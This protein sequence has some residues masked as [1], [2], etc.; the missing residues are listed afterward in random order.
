MNLW[1]F[2][3]KDNIG[4]DYYY[5][6]GLFLSSFDFHTERFAGNTNSSRTVAEELYLTDVEKEVNFAVESNRLWVAGN[7]GQ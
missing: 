5:K 1:L 7:T 2:I 6:Y 3:N 4:R